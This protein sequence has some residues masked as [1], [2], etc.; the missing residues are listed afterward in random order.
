MA[1]CDFDACSRG[2]DPSELGARISGVYADLLI[3]I[4]L[5]REGETWESV[6]GWRC[7]VMLV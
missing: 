1:G 6:R 2:S 3:D 4:I 7:G 5:S